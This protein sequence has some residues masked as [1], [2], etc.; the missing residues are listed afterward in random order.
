M[1]YFLLIVTVSLVTWVLFC[2]GSLRVLFAF[3][4][5]LSIDVIFPPDVS[6]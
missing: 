5:M 3:E 1:L 6:L 4:V 2:L